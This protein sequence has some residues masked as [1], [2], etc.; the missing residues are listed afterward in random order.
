MKVFDFK[1]DNGQGDL[2]LDFAAGKISFIAKENNPAFPAGDQ[3][4]ADLDPFLDKMIAKMPNWYTALGL[5][6]FKALL[7]SVT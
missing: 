1:F 7:D 2:K 3:F 6:A 4:Q 5:R